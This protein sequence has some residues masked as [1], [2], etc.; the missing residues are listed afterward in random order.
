MSS[1]VESPSLGSAGSMGLRV[2]H[3]PVNFA[4][5]GWTNVQALRA[6]GLDA[7]LVVFAA[8]P[9]HPEADLDLNLPDGPFL[10]RQALQ[11]RALAKLLPETDVFHFYFGLTLVPKRLQFP[12]LHAAR[13]RS[14]FHFLGSAPTTR[15][16]GSRRPRSFHPGSTFERSS[17]CRRERRARSG[18]RTPPC[19][20]TARGPLRSLP[21][22][23]SSVSSST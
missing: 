19:C 7:R 21:R 11:L 4:G 9:T 5:I 3:C 20:G 17:R 18:S 10:W 16:A 8:Q 23:R 12:I 1:G 2:T 15:R 13:K 6:K 14:V 22:A